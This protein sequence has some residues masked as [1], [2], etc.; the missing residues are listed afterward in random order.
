MKKRFSEAKIIGFL[1]EAE[2]GMP[3][4]DLCRRH[5]I[6]EALFQPWRSRFGGVG[7][8]DAK[9]LKEVE[10]E[11]ARLK[12]LLAKQI[13][14]ERRHQGRSPKKALTEPAKRELVR[15][16][17]VRGLSERRAL[18]AIRMSP[19]AFRYAPR[20]DRNVELREEIVALAHRHKR[21][22]VGMIHLKLRQAGRLVNYKRVERLYRDARLQV[23]RRRRKKVPIGERQP[24]LRPTGYSGS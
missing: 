14:R 21:Y 8:S 13:F 19:S 11:N 12:K 17:M 4:M 2:A 1:R 23:R 9:R 10:A 3:V 22:G 5:G 6:S 15:Q 18:R 7:V 20:P 16:M 24:L